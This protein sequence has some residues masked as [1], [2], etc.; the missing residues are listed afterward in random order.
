[1]TPRDDG[2]MGEVTRSTVDL[3][4]SVN[5]ALRRLALER[6]TTLQAIMAALATAVADGDQ[7]A[8][9]LLDRYLPDEAKSR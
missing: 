1:M 8:H 9:A 6:D 2:Y 3:P 7:A 4:K 5:R